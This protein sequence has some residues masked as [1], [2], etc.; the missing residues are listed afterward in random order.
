MEF[1]MKNSVGRV[2]KY[3]IDPRTGIAH[4]VYKRQ[5]QRRRRRHQPKL[6]ETTINKPQSTMTNYSRKKKQKNN[7]M[8]NEI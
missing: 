7:R 8:P 4:K 3:F 1:T 6:K 2:E 5:R